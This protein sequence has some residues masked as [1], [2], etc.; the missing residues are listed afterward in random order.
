MHLGLYYKF[1]RLAYYFLSNNFK[2]LSYP[3]AK[4]E[5]PTGFDRN[6]IPIVN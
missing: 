1:D 4:E 3:S 5:Q 6:L 2:Q